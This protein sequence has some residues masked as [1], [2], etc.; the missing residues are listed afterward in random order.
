MPPSGIHAAAH[1]KLASWHDTDGFSALVDDERH[2]GHVVMIEGQWC[3]F[4]GTRLSESGAGFVFLG[5]STSLGEAKR[6]AERKLLGNEVAEESGIDAGRTEIRRSTAVTRSLLDQSDPLDRLEVLL[7]LATTA[8]GR[9]EWSTARHLLRQ[10]AALA[11]SEAAHSTRPDLL[12]DLVR[13]S[14]RTISM[15]DREGATASLQ[16]CTELIHFL[17]EAVAG[18]SGLKKKGRN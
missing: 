5:A 6:I 12:E 15:K 10:L 18:R 9:F 7:A 14:G 17:R 4:D 8:A 11:R 1:S 2:L 16:N 3:A 13:K